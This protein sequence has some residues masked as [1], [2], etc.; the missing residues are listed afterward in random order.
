M[1]IVTRQLR[2]LEAANLS[3]AASEYTSFLDRL[4]RQNPFTR[5]PERDVRKLGALISTLNISRRLEED[6]ETFRVLHRLE[7][8]A[9]QAKAW[10]ES[11]DIRGRRA[12]V[13]E[14]QAEL[15]ATREQI[16]ALN[17][18]LEAL[19]EEW[20][21]TERPADAATDRLKRARQLLEAHRR[22]NA[23]VFEPAKAM[24][25]GATIRRGGL[26]MV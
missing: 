7:D 12:R 14:I 4:A 21:Q 19:G 5:L 1:T 3:A 20:K 22:E 26:N 17:Q 13:V 2:E 25:R 11:E 16:A 24:G 15:A 18:K 9:A 8:E 23:D 6:V 10:D